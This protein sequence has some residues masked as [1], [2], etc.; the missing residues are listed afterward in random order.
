MAENKTE[1]LSQLYA[2]RAGLSVIA[3][4]KD[5][6]DVIGSK[7]Q[8]EINNYK[9]EASELKKKK[10]S[11]KEEIENNQK[12][13]ELSQKNVDEQTGS[14]GKT[15]W[16]Y[17]KKII[18]AVVGLIAIAGV[19][20]GITRFLIN[21][22]NNSSKGFS[23]KIVF[24]LFIGVTILAAIAG[25]IAIIV[26]TA[27]ACISKFSS[28]KDQKKDYEQSVE[29]VTNLSKRILESQEE[30]EKCENR[31]MEIPSTISSLENKRN[32]DLL[33]YYIRGNA[34]YSALQEEYAPLLDERD[35]K[36][37]DLIIY[38][39]ETKRADCL[40]DALRYVDEERR[41]DRIVGAIERSTNQ[42]CQTIQTGM[43]K[44][45][46]C[47]VKCFEVLSDQIEENARRQRA[48]IKD[49]SSK[50]EGLAG[51]IDY[52][53][54]LRNYRHVSSNTLYAN[55]EVF[56]SQAKALIDNQAVRMRNNGGF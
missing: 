40:K 55:N 1:T 18:M 17:V 52:M 49:M 51:S 10:H 2:L 26:F 41:T 45:A 33:P 7:T 39:Y 38:A 25:G 5:A 42:I 22:Y 8:N 53:N 27:K 28:S 32:N 6:S 9:K 12:L 23:T 14:K 30:L 24:Y 47:M 11:L 44:M 48:L 13:V 4:E 50:I 3:Q 20:F 21:D 37:L 43:Q 46:T 35:W 19:A 56:I 31:A 36:D 54:A 34:I 15:T 29:N 16:D